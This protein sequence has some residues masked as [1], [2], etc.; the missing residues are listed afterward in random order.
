[1]SPT[2]ARRRFK[3]RSTTDRKPILL[4]IGLPGID[5]FEVARRLRGQA[6]TRKAVLIAMT[7]YGQ[8]SDKVRASR[9]GFDHYLVKPADPTQLRFFWRNWSSGSD[10]HEPEP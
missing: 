10:P 1:M 7:G 9:V 3:R 8:E 5:G 2:P 6:E 4:D